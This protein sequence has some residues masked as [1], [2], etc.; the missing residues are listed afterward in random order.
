MAPEATGIADLVKASLTTFK[1][2]LN[3]LS[4]NPLRKVAT[5]AWEDEAGR[6]RIWS[7]NLGA[8]Q[9]GSW[10]LA[11]R[12][13]RAP[14]I[15]KGI[16]ETLEVLLKAVKEAAEILQDCDH[17]AVVDEEYIMEIYRDVVDSIEGLFRLSTV[18]RNPSRRDQIMER[19]H[20]DK[21][22]ESTDKG[23]IRDMLPG[24]PDALV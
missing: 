17:E 7:G 6:L 20:D 21:R 19:T 11:Y 13:R 12:L 3:S 14:S 23:R 22:M 18:I 4:R 1:Q 8:H 10:S 15:E 16:M 5:A 2:L 24:A 9:I